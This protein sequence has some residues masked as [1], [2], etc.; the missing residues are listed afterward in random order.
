MKVNSNSGI[1]TCLTHGLLIPNVRLSSNGNYNIYHNNAVLNSTK[2]K[3][4]T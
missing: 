3:F 1:S 4:K 2:N